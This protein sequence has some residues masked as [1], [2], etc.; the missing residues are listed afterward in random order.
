MT[1]PVKKKGGQTNRQTERL[2]T[3]F[4]KDTSGQPETIS[5]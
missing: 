5:Q 2:T 1:S 3:N 4:T